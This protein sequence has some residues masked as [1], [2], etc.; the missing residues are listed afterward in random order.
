[1]CCTLQQYAI[2]GNIKVSLSPVGNGVDVCTD[3]EI[4]T[5]CRLTLMDSLIAGMRLENQIVIHAKQ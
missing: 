5:L 2:Q 4:Q 1:M 3:L